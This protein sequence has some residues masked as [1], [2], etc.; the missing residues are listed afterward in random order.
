MRWQA[1]GASEQRGYG[2]R[3]NEIVTNKP[4]RLSLQQDDTAS[5]DPSTPMRSK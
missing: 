2:A 3:R 4:F 1:T 5:R